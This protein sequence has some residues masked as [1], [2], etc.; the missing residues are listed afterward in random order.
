MSRILHHVGRNDFKKTRQRQIDE[1]KEHAAQKLKELQEAEVERKQ[2]EEASRPYKS[3]WREET[4]LQDSDW[5]PVSGS[6]ANSTSQ[7]FVH[8]TGATTTVS[9]LGGVET[10]PSTVTI[11]VFGD[12]FDVPAPEYSQYGMQGYAKP[13]SNEVM[14][15]NAAYEKELEEFRKKQD[16]NL[17]KI[18]DTLESLGT[19]W[20]EMRANNWAIVKP[21]GTSI[22]LEPITPGNRQ[23]NWIDNSKITVGKK[24]RNAG[25]NQNPFKVRNPD[26]SITIEFS[27]IKSVKK[28]EI[29]ERPSVNS[30]LDASQ[31]FAQQVGAD[32]LMN[33]RVQDLTPL[34]KNPF[35]GSA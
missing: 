31:E 14:K 17:Q 16:D 29:G 8:S 26:G 34:S 28:F 10:T 23:L 24:H 15:R 5:T 27:E 33:A 6:I 2:I 9:G 18:K 13:L 3:N 21:D 22:M 1:Q 4:Q 35:K 19:S 25:P 32:E 20:E 30:Q 11:D 12:R 7:T